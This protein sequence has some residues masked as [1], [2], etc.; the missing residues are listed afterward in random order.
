MLVSDKSSHLSS[1]EH[2]QSTKQQPI[3]CEDCGKGISDKTRHFQSVIHILES[4]HHQQ[5]NFGQD[6]GLNVNEKHTSN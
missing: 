2:E 4:Q 5:S 1:N 3:W 6:V